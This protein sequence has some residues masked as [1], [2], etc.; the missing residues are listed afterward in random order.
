MGV[1]IDRSGW[2][3]D[4]RWAAVFILSALAAGCGQRP[5]DY[6][7]EDFISVLIEKCRQ[8]YQTR[9]VVK[10]AGDT[11]WVYLPYTP[12]RQGR[13]ASLRKGD[14]L[15]VEYAIASFNPFRPKDPPELRFLVQKV[16]GEV[17]EAF[18]RTHPPY[19]YFVL[20][21]TDIASPLAFQEDWYYGYLDDVKNYK[22]GAD[23]SGEG[24]SRLAW[25]PQFL[26]VAPGEE[27]KP[28]EEGE[29]DEGAEP[30]GEAKLVSEAYGDAR[31][32]HVKVHEVTLD[33]FIERQITWRVYKQFTI[34]YLKTPFDM[35][36][37]EKQDAVLRIVRT[38]FIAYNYKEADKIHLRDS[39]FLDSEQAYNVWS[40]SDLEE[41]QRDFLPLRKSGF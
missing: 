11:V 34:G 15:Y 39:S 36:R 35:T 3:R 6:S 26:E 8:K 20:V 7:R 5:A 31:G 1:K 29:P 4:R 38:V 2:Q 14:G 19:A 10:E 30:G 18:L 17:R 12:G 22:V 33:E 27:A 28:G 41:R 9:L 21:A 13:A 23:F 32:D 16:L 37:Q 40:R 25:Y 24:Y